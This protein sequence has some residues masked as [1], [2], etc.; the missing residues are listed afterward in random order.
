MVK[1]KRSAD[2][3]EDDEDDVP[4][5]G[6]TDPIFKVLS[7]PIRRRILEKLT[8]EPHYPLQLSKELRIS[9][10]AATKHLDV[11]ERYGMIEAVTVPS[12]S[13][14]P[15]RVYQARKSYSISVFL[16]PNLYEVKVE[17]LTVMQ[18]Q[19]M[20]PRDDEVEAKPKEK[21]EDGAETAPEA[22]LSSPA[23]SVE[24]FVDRYRQALH[25][26]NYK[27]KVRTLAEITDE[28]NIELDHLNEKRIQLLRIKEASVREA[29][30]IIEELYKDYYER[31]I[32]YSLMNDV[33]ASVPQMSRELAIRERMVRE[34]IRKLMEDDILR[35]V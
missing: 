24:E 35:R 18:G 9:Q 33:D 11:L 23:D 6:D 14:P 28:I 4:M 13:G 22:P 17:P 25:L 16:G 34:L 31:N 15:R 1:R 2:A 32:L 7:N 20:V 30:A 21:G 3:E 8:R 5:D 27:D 10:Q 12:K 29:N 19:T 26:Q